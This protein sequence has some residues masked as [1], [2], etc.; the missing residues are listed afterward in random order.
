MR[1]L[2]ISVLLLAASSLAADRDLAGGYSGEW[3]STASEY[4]GTLRFVLENDG[5]VWK[6]TASFTMEGTEVPCTMRT[7]KVQDGKIELVYEF[8]TQGTLLRS[9]QKGEWKD[10]EFRGSYS[11]ATADGQGIDQGTWS[12][13]RK[14]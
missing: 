13:K 2:L 7:V 1:F 11:T 9:T 4:G 8:E 6:G 5:G 3:K 12:A 10:L 14:G